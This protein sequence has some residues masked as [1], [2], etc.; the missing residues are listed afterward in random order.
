MKESVEIIQSFLVHVPL[1]KQKAVITNPEGT[2]INWY[3]FGR[4]SR[5]VLFTCIPQVAGALIGIIFVGL[6]LQAVSISKKK[7]PQNDRLV[8]GPATCWLW[9]SFNC[10]EDTHMKIALF[11]SGTEL[12]PLYQRPLRLYYLELQM[13]LENL[14][15]SHAHLSSIDYNFFWV[16]PVTCN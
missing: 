6:P 14:E 4:A 2:C 9:G 10:G 12:N 3:W 15:K 7:N 5:E 16:I 1:V 13:N 8:P 11:I